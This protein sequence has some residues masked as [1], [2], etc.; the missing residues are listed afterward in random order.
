[1][2]NM[3]IM[4]KKSKA[5]TV[6]AK[7]SKTTKPKIKKSNTKTLMTKELKTKVYNKT[8]DE[9]IIHGIIKKIKSKKE[10]VNLDEELCHQYITK[11][12][13]EHTKVLR[14]FTKAEDFSKISKSKETAETV[15]WVRKKIREVYGLFQTKDLSKAEELLVKLDDELRI[16]P[17]KE[18]L[19]IHKKLLA[20][21][22]STNERLSIYPIFYDKIFEITGKP[23]SIF[24]FASGFNPFSFPYTGLKKI[25]YIATELNNEDVSLIQEYFRIVKVNGNAFRLDLN[26][27]M[28]KINGIKVDMCIALKLFD[29]VDTK[30][31]EKVIKDIDAEWIVASFPTKTATQQDMKFKRRAGFQ[32]MLRRLKLEYKTITFNNEL[33]YVIKKKETKKAKA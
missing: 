20:T 8:V 1:M 24:E 9:D 32:K 6:K 3:P 11:F 25:E 16:K 4:K 12:L 33:V 29:L 13:T 31:T 17:L 18:T 26:N 2:N 30:I 19:G 5:K 15:K 14:K 10:L 28:N 21:H 27:D 23:G 7:K 22:M